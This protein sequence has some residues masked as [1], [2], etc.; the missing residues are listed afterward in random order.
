M[1]VGQSATV[2]FDAL[3]DGTRDRHGDGRRHPAHDRRQRLTTYGATI[4]L[5]EVPEG[6]RDGMSASVVVTVDEATDVLWAPTAAITTAGGQS[7]VTVRKDG[8]DTTVAV[9]TGLAGD[10]GTE[11]TSGV[12]EGD[13]LVVSTTDGSGGFTASRWAAS[14]AGS[15]AE[16]AA[17]GGPPA[18]RRRIVTPVIALAASPRCTAPARPRSTR[19][20]ASTSTV[21]RGDYV[22]IMGTSGSGKSTLMNIIGALDVRVGRATTSSTASTSTPSTSR[23]CRSCATARSASSS[24]PSTSSPARPRSP[25]SSCRS[26]TGGSSAGSGWREPRAALAAVGLADRMDHEPNELSG[27]QQQRVAVARALVA[28]PSLLLADEPTG[29]LDSRSTTDVLD[30]MDGVHLEGRT[31]V[32]ITHEDDVAARADR[33]ITLVDGAISDDRWNRPRG[34][35]GLPRC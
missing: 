25:T 17:A 27:G 23:P 21:E 9:T 24:S 5:D 28:E 35:A 19:C 7:T 13:E 26:S 15:P 29:N 32:M 22:A 8:V 16:A 12:A 18:G 30:L 6:L 4:T 14:R 1:E 31:I 10:S 3:T 34:A 11:I 33:V 2:T 20:A